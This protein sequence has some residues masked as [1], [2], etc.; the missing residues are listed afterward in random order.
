[1]VG[2]S[3]PL[4]LFDATTELIIPLLKSKYQETGKDAL[5]ATNFGCSA[6]ESPG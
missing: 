2:I 6:S 4:N 1:M 3:A 5:N